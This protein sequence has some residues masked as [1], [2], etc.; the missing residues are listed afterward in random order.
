[1]YD[2]NRFQNKSRFPFVFNTFTV[3]SNGTYV[4]SSDFRLDQHDEWLMVRNGSVY[5]WRDESTGMWN[6]NY[7]DLIHCF[8]EDLREYAKQ[9]EV[10]PR[11]SSGSGKLRLVQANV[12]TTSSRI[13]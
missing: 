13:C 1:M 3:K 7:F 9:F 2:E 5:A 4:I 12:S 6:Q 10:Y 8:D 11:R